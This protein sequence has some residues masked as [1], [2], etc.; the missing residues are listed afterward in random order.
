DLP[1]IENVIEHPDSNHVVNVIKSDDHFDQKVI[2]KKV[3]EAKTASKKQDDVGDSKTESEDNDIPNNP[4][5]PT[6][7]A[8]IG[9][10]IITNFFINVLYVTG[11]AL[12]F[13]VVIVAPILI[14]MW[15]RYLTILK[16]KNKLHTPGKLSNSGAAILT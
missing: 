6:V 10:A 12:I 14:Y 9:S 1:D 5:W 15:I 8:S 4:S 7:W 13:P 11:W 16:R 3:I 2:P